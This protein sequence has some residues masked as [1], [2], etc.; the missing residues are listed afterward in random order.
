[1]SALNSSNGKVR[2]IITD[3]SWSYSFPMIKNSEIVS[4]LP[5]VL[6]DFLN[7]DG[8]K[9]IKFKNK[10][11]WDIYFVWRKR[12]YCTLEEESVIKVFKEEFNH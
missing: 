10:I 8:V 12:E 7:M 3:Y 6:K 11:P 1:M 4:F 9:C 2:S 5:I